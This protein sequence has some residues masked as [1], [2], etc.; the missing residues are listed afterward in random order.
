[1]DEAPLDRLHVS[2]EKA[3]SRWMNKE[4]AADDS[5][6]TVGYVGDNISRH[7]TVAAMAVL[8]STVD[9]NQYCDREQLRK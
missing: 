8:R 6:A 5:W 7:M 4:A 3:I 2:L 1:M 9:L